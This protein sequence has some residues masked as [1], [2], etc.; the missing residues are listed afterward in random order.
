VKLSAIYSV[1]RTGIQTGFVLLLLPAWASGQSRPGAACEPSPEIRAQLERAT[2]VVARP[3]DFDQRIAPFLA[4]RD[5]YPHDLSVHESYQ[6]AVQRYGIEGHLR[7]LTEDYQVLSMQHPDDPTYRYLYARS[8][9]GRNTRSAIQQMTELL[10]EHAEF[11]SAQRALAEIYTSATF[12]DAEKEKIEREHFFALCPGSALQQRPAALSNPSPLID[13][14][15]RLLAE[16]GDPERAAAL[17]LQGIRDDEWRLQRIRPF[18]WYSVDFK[19]QSQRELQGKYWRLWSIQVRRERRA[20]QPEKA[21]DMLLLMDERAALLRKDSDPA[22]WNALAT[23]V[24]LYE[25]GNQ[26]DS[27][28][29]KLDS[30]QQFLAQHPDPSRTAQLEGLRKLIEANQK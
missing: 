2:V 21:A 30:M 9:I 16:N 27:A 8:L 1:S 22:Y 7:K 28:L 26:K 5:R 19:R 12:H 20:G 25:E 23:L 24:V 11:A 18:D 3:S 4:L 14:A 10:G 13:Q 6:D 15:E 17:A 29:R